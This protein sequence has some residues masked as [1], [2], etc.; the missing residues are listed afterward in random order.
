MVVFAMGPQ[1]V[2]RA[3]KA[4]WRARAFLEDDQLDLRVTKQR[5]LGVST[6][7]VLQEWVETGCTWL[8]RVCDLSR[9]CW[10]AVYWT[11][12]RVRSNARLCL[13]RGYWKRIR[14]TRVN[15]T[16]IANLSR[17]AQV[18]PEF[19]HGEGNETFSTKIALHIQSYKLEP[20]QHENAAASA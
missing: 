1:A 14:G 15:E 18:V 2:T 4:V 3:L 8:S 6:A 12:L 13:N 7:E 5:H 20:E 11:R 16:H 10:K 17:A 9:V 19:K